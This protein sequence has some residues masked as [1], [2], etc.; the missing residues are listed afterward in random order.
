M[1]RGYGHC[2]FGASAQ[3]LYDMRGGHADTVNRASLTRDNLA[4][5]FSDVILN[6]LAT[7]TG[8]CG[9]DSVCRLNDK[10]KRCRRVNVVVVRLNGVDNILVLAILG[11]KV[12]TELNV[13]AVNLSCHSLTYIV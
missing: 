9:A 2:R 7:R 10:V 1:Q 11:S 6:V 3:C 8:S 5:R 13:R 12:N 4:A